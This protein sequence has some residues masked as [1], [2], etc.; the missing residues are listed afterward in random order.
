MATSLARGRYIAYL[1]SDDVYFPGST[2]SVSWR[3]WRAPDVYLAY[4]PLLGPRYRGP[5]LQGEG[6]VG[7]E[8][9]ASPGPTPGRRRWDPSGNLLALVQVCHRREWEGEVRWAT[10]EEAVT[11]RLEADVWR[12]LLSRGARFAYSGAV[13]CHWVDHPDQQH[14]IIGW[15]RIDNAPGAVL[16]DAGRGRAAYRAYYGVGRGEY[17]NWRP[18]AGGPF[19]EAYAYAGLAAPATCPP[20]GATDPPGRRAGLQPRARPGLRG[21][22]AQAARPLGAPPPV[23]GR[24]PLPIREHRGGP[25]PG[26]WRARVRAAR[27]DVIYALLNWQALPLIEALLDA[28]L[29]IPI[30]FHFK[31]GPHFCQRYGLWPVLLRALTESDGQILISRESL[32]YV[33]LATPGGL[34]PARVLLLDGDLPRGPG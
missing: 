4:R 22:G 3:T 16:G 15:G 34:D 9:A 17:L 18:S 1:P 24:R 19:D 32:D 27:P 31:E 11:D 20:R 2:C 12:A 10:R 14:K 29:G 23:L 8:L 7:G 13:T 6:A 30:V 33:S 26:D 25:I 21:A 28:R 5:T